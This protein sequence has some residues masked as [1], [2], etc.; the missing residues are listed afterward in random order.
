MY[1]Q[2]LREMEDKQVNPLVD[3]LVLGKL[4]GCS[5]IC[6]LAFHKS[7]PLLKEMLD[8]GPGQVV[9]VQGASDIIV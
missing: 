2:L 3:P 5:M 8:D 9:R 7:F 6:F 4:G 1:P